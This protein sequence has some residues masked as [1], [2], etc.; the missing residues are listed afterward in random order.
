MNIFFRFMVFILGIGHVSQLQAQT[1]PLPSTELS[2]VILSKP[3]VGPKI[4][5][6]SDVRLSN[7]RLS[8]I[9]HLAVDGSLRPMNMVQGSFSAPIEGLAVA[10][11]LIITLRNQSHVSIGEFRN[12]DRHISPTTPIVFS[13]DNPDYLVQIDVSDKMIRDGESI[14]IGVNTKWQEEFD[15]Q[16][17]ANVSEIL[18]LLRAFA[19]ERSKLG[20]LQYAGALFTAE[21]SRYAKDLIPILRKIYMD[22]VVTPANGKYHIENF[23]DVYSGNTDSTIDTMQQQYQPPTPSEA[24]Q[25]PDTHSYDGLLV[26]RPRPSGGTNSMTFADIAPS[27]SIDD[28]EKFYRLLRAYIQ[29][30][31]DGV[32]LK[33]TFASAVQT[34]LIWQG[35]DNIKGI[36]SPSI[37]YQPIS[38]EIAKDTYGWNIG[39]YFHVLKIT[40]KNERPDGKTIV[41]KGNTLKIPM[42]TVSCQYAN[43]R[44]AKLL[45]GKSFSD[46][47]IDREKKSW[48]YTHSGAWRMTHFAG[49]REVSGKYLFG[50]RVYEPFA[51]DMVAAGYMIREGKSPTSVVLRT[52]DT[53]IAAGANAVPF[54]GSPVYQAVAGLSA[55][56]G[57][58]LLGKWFLDSTQIAQQQNEFRRE[59]MPEQFTLQRG[60]D[61]ARVVVVPKF[62]I[63]FSD[64]GSVESLKSVTFYYG[65]APQQ[66]AQVDILIVEDQ[67]SVA[68]PFTPANVTIPN[69]STNKP[70]GF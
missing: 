1:I 65:A 54:V 5:E 12:G 8:F 20:D 25:F 30:Q 60:A 4:K 63:D 31:S 42:A 44:E 38:D 3:K 14:A 35:D 43:S 69:V 33:Q 16:L 67:K 17:K 22:E 64:T 50:T 49:K 6:I 41:V 10:P 51:T 57:R 32:S 52:A 53:L 11:N 59:A 23:D 40:F 15:R 26:G 70:A 21:S 29:Y 2:A 61:Q 19:Q 18:P 48:S 56:S 58:E 39:R 46:V 66:Q 47:S 37:T 34:S 13:N 62:G 68:A 45:I 7:S 9:I 24:R 55:G 27:A 28:K 36:E